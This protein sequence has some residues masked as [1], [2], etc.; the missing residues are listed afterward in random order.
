MNVSKSITKEPVVFQASIFPALCAVLLGLLLC[1]C[2]KAA[3][4]APLPP[5]VQV[6]EVVATNAAFNTELIGQ[7]DSP[8]NVEVRARVEAFV[9][10]MLF[11]EGQEVQKDSRLFQL[12]ESPY[13]QRLNAAEAMLA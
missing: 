10:K 7:L 9:D 5:V 6:L 4:T 3:P 1:G 12:D 13:K 11:T 2:K 8:Q